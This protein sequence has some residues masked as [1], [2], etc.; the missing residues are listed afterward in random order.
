MIKVC[1]IVLKA[2]EMI[3]VV[4]EGTVDDYQIVSTSF[5]KYKLAEP[6]D[7]EAVKKFKSDIHEFFDYED[8][9]AIG[10]KERI[11]KG[12]FA[13]GAMT[14]KMEGLIQITDYPVQIIHSNRI[15]AKT[16]DKIIPIDEV[17]KYQEDALLTAFY[18]LHEAQ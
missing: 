3:S 8:F 2:N 13:G 12:R 11:A 7:Q 16:K 6:K 15:K 1:G 5:D 14:F 10:I 18:L 9:H 4:L 17:K